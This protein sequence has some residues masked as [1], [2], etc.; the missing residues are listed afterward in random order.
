[1]PRLKTF[2]EYIRSQIYLS[3]NLKDALKNKDQNL[4]LSLRDIDVSSRGYKNKYISEQ[5]YTQLDLMFLRQF[6]TPQEEHFSN[7]DFK[8]EDIQKQFLKNF[9]RMSFIPLQRLL[10]NVFPRDE[11]IFHCTDVYPGQKIQNSGDANTILHF[12]AMYTTLGFE[13]IDHIGKIMKKDSIV[14]PFI[15]NTAMK[16]PLDITVQLGD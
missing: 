4:R 1:M 2:Y 9:K 13:C 5:S 10:C 14:I 11:E 15:P 3:G 16:T 12:L 8:P 6:F 7:E